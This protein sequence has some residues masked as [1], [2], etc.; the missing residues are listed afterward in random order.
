MIMHL[1]HI[2]YQRTMVLVKGNF[3]DSDNN[4]WIRGASGNRGLRNSN[5]HE[6]WLI[7]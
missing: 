2:I 5:L 7:P 3:H 4:H 6:A 1:T